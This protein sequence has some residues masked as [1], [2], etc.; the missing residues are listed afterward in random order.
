MP[1]QEIN[2]HYVPIEW[3]K[4]IHDETDEAMDDITLQSIPFLRMVNNDYLADAFFYLS[5]DRGQS[6]INHVT[7]TFNEAYA[8]FMHD[9]PLFNG[10]IAILAYSLG[11]IITWD[12]LA[13][14]PR[15]DLPATTTHSKLD[16][17]F[18]LLHFKPDY[19]FGLGCPLSA[20]LTVRNQDP[21]LYRP[22][23]SIIFENIFHPFDPLA[24]RFE[25]MMNPDYK[26]ESAVLVEA[27]GGE[28]TT[29]PHALQRVWNK[30]VDLIQTLLTP[31]TSAG[32]P[33]SYPIEDDDG[34]ATPKLSLDCGSDEDDDLDSPRDLIVAEERSIYISHKRRSLVID[35]EEAVT[36]LG[37]WRST[38]K[39][40][41]EDEE[42]LLRSTVTR[43]GA[44]AT[45]HRVRNRRPLMRR[46]DYVLRPER[47]WLGLVAKNAYLSGL[48]AHF[49][50]WTNRDLMWHIVRRLEGIN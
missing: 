30:G 46:M 35:D 23:P 22:D 12:I 16:F 9:H 33:P 8:R 11:G 44:V 49:S 27:S 40:K 2:V 19:F 21:K 20:F 14:Q 26:N 36:D 34:M 7:R 31:I 42:C 48:T 37:L 32:T 1:G 4:H 25:P 5:R 41:T 28:M 39:Q 17:D 3:H 18:P 10:K 47:I 15:P 29:E 38:K 43:N 6:I 45:S 24:Y 50:Y 13:N